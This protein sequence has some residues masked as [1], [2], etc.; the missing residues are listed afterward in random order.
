MEIG[1]KLLPE[2]R[3]INA[4]VFDWRELDLGRYD[5][6]IGNPPFGRVKRQGMARVIAVRTSSFTLSI[7]LLS[8]PTMALSSCRSSPPAFA[9]PERS[10]TNVLRRGAASISSVRPALK[11][12]AAQVS[13]RLLS[14]QMEGRCPLCEIVCIEFAECRE[15]MKA[16]RDRIAARPMPQIMRQAE[17]LALL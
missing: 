13:T 3:W 6:A 1:R 15:R 7:S 9:I 10:F 5:C 17:Q 12:W 2:A 4:D 11:W 8:L 14:R 16:E